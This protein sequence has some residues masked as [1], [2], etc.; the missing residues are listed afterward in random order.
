MSECNH[1]PIASLERLTARRESRETLRRSRRIASA[2]NG[3]SRE[4]EVVQAVYLLLSQEGTL[5]GELAEEIVARAFRH[6][7]P[8][9]RDAPAPKAGPWTEEAN[10]SL[11]SP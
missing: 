9:A 10:L 5:V 11:S 1:Q 4:E 8:S 6:G 2:I 7:P 3:R